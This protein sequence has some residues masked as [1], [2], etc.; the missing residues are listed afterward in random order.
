MTPETTPAAAT[1][2]TAAAKYELLQTVAYATGG[3]SSHRATF[4]GRAEDARK[5]RIGRLRTQSRPFMLDG[6]SVIYDER[7]GDQVRLE[8]VQL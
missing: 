1:S 7:S 8:W 2:T 6:K 5:E 3:S 4:A